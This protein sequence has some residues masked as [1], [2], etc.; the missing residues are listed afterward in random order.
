MKVT[1]TVVQRAPNALVGAEVRM[2]RLPQ[3]FVLLLNFSGPDGYPFM[4]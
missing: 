3:N 2:V 4:V 1:N